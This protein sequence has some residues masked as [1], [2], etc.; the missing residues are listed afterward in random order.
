MIHNQKY[1]IIELLIKH[2]IQINSNLNKPGG[3]GTECVLLQIGVKYF[4]VS[5]M[6]TYIV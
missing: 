6:L 3:E 1:Q 2:A 4:K 5:D